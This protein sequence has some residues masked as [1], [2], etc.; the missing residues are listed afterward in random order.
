MEDTLLKPPSFEKR[1]TRR[2]HLIYYPRVIDR[3]CSTEL[4]HLVDL[5][6]DGIMLMSREPLALDEVYDLRVVLPE[7]LGDQTE[8]EFRARVRWSSVDVNDD[9]FDTGLQLIDADEDHVA[10]VRRLVTTYGFADN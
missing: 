1:E 2:R 9:Y 6:H 7:A 10:R 4:G 8:L 5:T 3:S